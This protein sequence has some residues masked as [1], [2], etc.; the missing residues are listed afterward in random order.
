MAKFDTFTLF[1]QLCCPR[2]LLLGVRGFPPGQ[3]LPVQPR[4]GHPSTEECFQGNQ[5][6]LLPPVKTD[7]RL[8]LLIY[9]CKR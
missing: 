4:L 9:D 1:R 8:V 7:V 2:C 6:N 3:K 5:T